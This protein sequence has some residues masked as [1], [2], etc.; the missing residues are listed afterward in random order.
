M[1]W[2]F[3]EDVEAFA[4]EVKIDDER[5]FLLGYV[6]SPIRAVTRTTVPTRGKFHKKLFSSLQNLLDFLRVR[7][8][9]LHLTQLKLPANFRSRN[10]VERKRPVRL[11]S[12]FALT[13][14]AQIF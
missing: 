2:F 3:E 8:A 6:T 13:M 7:H 12:L 5:I 9:P 4:V 1:K 10:I 14:L 11:P